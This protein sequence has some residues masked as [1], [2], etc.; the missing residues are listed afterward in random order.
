MQPQFFDYLPYYSQHS[1]PAR[2]VN[3]T[4]RFSFNHHK[5]KTLDKATMIV[6]TYD[7]VFTSDFCVLRGV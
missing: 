7:F 4:L 1:Q 6:D 5:I 3:Q 2:N